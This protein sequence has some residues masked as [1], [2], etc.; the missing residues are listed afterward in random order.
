MCVHKSIPDTQTE[1][2][3][4]LS[5]SP[6]VTEPVGLGWATQHPQ[7]VPNEWGPLWLGASHKRGHSPSG[8]WHRELLPHRSRGPGGRKPETSTVRLSKRNRS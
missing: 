8:C 6:R 4:R 7:L 5:A 2:Q 3:Q 1:T